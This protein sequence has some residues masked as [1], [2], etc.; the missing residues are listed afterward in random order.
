MKIIKILQE[1]I[2]YE[3]LEVG[4]DYI[5]ID[6]VTYQGLSIECWKSIKCDEEFITLARISK[7]LELTSKCNKAILAGFETV[8]GKFYQ[9]DEKDQTNF[10]QQTILIMMDSSVTTVTWE[11]GNQD[12]KFAE[13]TKEE[14]LQLIG[15][16][17]Q[18]KNT[19]ISKLTTL[20]NQL[21]SAKTIEEIKSIEW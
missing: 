13:Y 7:Y 19:K 11:S 14:F 9:F 16:A 8:D 10:T 6:D 20:R 4:A 1:E 18:H 15:L 12:G 2:E 17:Q 21:D 5:K 3:N